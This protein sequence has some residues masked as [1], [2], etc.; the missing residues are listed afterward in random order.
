[1]KPTREVLAAVARA[2]AEGR[3]R[4]MKPR[5]KVQP[6]PVTF[7]LTCQVRSEQNQRCHWAVRHRR[8]KAQAAAL[9]VV[10]RASVTGELPLPLRVTFTHL[11][12]RMDEHDGLRAA[13]KGLVDAAAKLIGVDDGDPRVTWQ[14]AQISAG[15]GILVKIEAA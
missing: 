14:Y 13:F 8:F 7:A 6:L 12:R 9:A 15:K 11:G 5:R 3:V 10:W 4:D 1:M 2:E